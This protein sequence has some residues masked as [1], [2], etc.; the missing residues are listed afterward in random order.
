VPA[1]KKRRVVALVTGCPR[2]P[3]SVAMARER[4]APSRARRGGTSRLRRR[5]PL[6]SPRLPRSHIRLVPGAERLAPGPRPR[7]QAPRSQ[8][9]CVRS[10]QTPMCAKLI[11]AIATAYAAAAPI[12]ASATAPRARSQF[13]AGDGRE[14]GSR[15]LT[16]ATPGG[17]GN[18]LLPSASNTGATRAA[19]PRCR[20]SARSRRDTVR[21]GSLGRARGR[22]RRRPPTASRP[23]RERA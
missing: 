21:A 15:W 20:F 5:R 12:A 23:G 4:R 13:A 6:P 2:A 14:S 3:R 7:E 18:G 10:R 11:T 8:A 9:R 19:Q 22:D 16:I 17:P 1:K